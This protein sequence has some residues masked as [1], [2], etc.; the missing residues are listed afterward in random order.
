M[1]RWL[2]I[3]GLAYFPAIITFMWFADESLFWDKF[4]FIIEKTL[5]CIALFCA[6]EKEVVRV[7]KR[8]ALSLV[9]L[10]LVFLIYIVTDW[11]EVVMF[12][13]YTILVACLIYLGVLILNIYKHDRKD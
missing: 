7:R 1:S 10:N 3:A 12:D 13:N 9:A 11:S 5:L 2:Y 6:V 4:Y 8:L